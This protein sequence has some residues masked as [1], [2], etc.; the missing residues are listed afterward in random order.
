MRWL[1][2]HPGLQE[3][4]AALQPGETLGRPRG[5]SPGAAHPLF[6]PLKLLFGLDFIVV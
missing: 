2:A 5:L 3:R 6:M 4:W 1:D